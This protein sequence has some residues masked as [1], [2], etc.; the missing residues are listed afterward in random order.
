[1]PARGDLILVVTMRSAGEIEEPGDRVLIAGFNALLEDR[2][3]R[4]YIKN[5]NHVILAASGAV[6]RCRAGENACTDPIRKTVYDL[7]PEAEAD[8]LYRVESQLLAGGRRVM[9]TR[10]WTL[11]DSSERQIAGR[12]YA[13]HGPG[14]QIV[15]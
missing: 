10:L 1:N 3:D 14:G 13:L 6:S 12:E 4:F 2:P 15:G 7:F 9:A 11:E 5:R 8:H